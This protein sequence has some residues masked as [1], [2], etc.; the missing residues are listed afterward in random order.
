VT[1]LRLVPRPNDVVRIGMIM[2]IISIILFG[3]SFYPLYTILPN[4]KYWDSTVSVETETC[5]KVEVGLILKGN[6][7]IGKIFECNSQ[8]ISLSLEDSLG[9][10]VYGPLLAD[11]SCSFVFQAQKDDFYYLSLDNTYSSIGSSSSYLKTVL[12][13]I[14][15]YGDY[16]L[17]FRVS[18]SILL[19]CGIICIILY[20]FMLKPGAEGF[21]VEAI[22]E[23][24]IKKIIGRYRRRND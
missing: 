21:H 19:I 1:I 14:Y 18:G 24:T 2:A 17:I 12:W 22:A 23:K 6:I 3:L 4:L 13:K 9:N 10:T 5:K 7:F 15:Y 20:E 11:G 8:K 16:S